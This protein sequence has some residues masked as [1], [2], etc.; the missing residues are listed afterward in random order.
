M[1][2]STPTGGTVLHT[3]KAAQQQPTRKCIWGLLAHSKGAS[4]APLVVQ[5]RPKPHV[6]TCPK[7]HIQHTSQHPPEG[8][9]P[10]VGI[11][12]LLA[13]GSQ[14]LLPPLLPGLG[15]L[16]KAYVSP[17]LAVERVVIEA[18]GKGTRLRDR[19]CHN[20]ATML[21]HASKPCLGQAGGKLWHASQRTH[22]RPLGQSHQEE[23]AGF[24]WIAPSSSGLC[25]QGKR[26]AWSGAIITVC[27][28]AIGYRA[29]RYFVGAGHI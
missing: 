15:A 19:Q 3:V 6:S 27:S 5:R 8:A 24:S 12:V 25:Q 7:P 22:W 28:S 18:G 23:L 4:P 16:H 9:I 13:Q 26:K 20:S 1:R 21:C 10:E 14:P 17:S 2:C 29:Q 11:R